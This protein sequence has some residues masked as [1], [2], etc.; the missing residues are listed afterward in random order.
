LWKR[1]Q[2][3]PLLE[4][5][6]KIAN[7]FVLTCGLNAVWIMMWHLLQIELSLLFMLW[8]LATLIV[9]YKKLQPHRTKLKRLSSLLLYVPFVVYL[10]WISVATIAN[11]TALLV[12]YKWNGF[13]VDA[14][15]W[16]CIMITVAAFL[17][18]FFSIFRKDFFYT[19]VTVWALYGI[20]VSQK[21][22]NEIVTIA[23]T[24]IGICLL[25]I[26]IGM[27]RT[28]KLKHA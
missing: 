16:S 4:I 1:D 28:I 20:S 14:V 22:Y 17:G 3:S 18:A 2:S 8:F 9:I 10:G 19:L 26:V 6:I 27:I 13:G 15:M 5:V 25:M 21:N 7:Y 12:H 24:G 23:Y 11:T